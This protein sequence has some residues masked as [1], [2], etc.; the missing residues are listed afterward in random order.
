MDGIH[1][2]GGMQGFGVVR[3]EDDEPVF[4]EPWQRM[5]FGLMIASQAVLRDHNADEYRHAVER[6]EPVHYLQSHYYERMFTGTTTLLVESGVLDAEELSK[7][8]GGPVPLARP[9][10]H[11]PVVDLAPQPEPRFGVGDLVTV[12][13]IDPRGHVRAPRFCRGKAG[14]VLQIAPRFRF[15]DTSAHGGERRLEHTYHVEFA[16]TELWGDEANPK[17][18][19]VVDLWDSYLEDTGE[20]GKPEELGGGES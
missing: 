3:R 5:A 18:S 13:N 16:A 8:A 20:P 6:M 10:D 19:V 12:R 4:H 14:R 15:P 17:D 7:S 2:L 1:D 9:V 11:R